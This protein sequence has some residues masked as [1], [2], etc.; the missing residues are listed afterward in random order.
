MI[1][2]GENNRGNDNKIVQR[3]SY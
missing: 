3:R 2:C 1:Q